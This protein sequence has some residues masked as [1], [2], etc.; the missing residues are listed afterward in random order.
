VTP[1]TAG[2]IGGTGSA[3]SAV[4]TAR[5]VPRRPGPAHRRTRARRGPGRS[6]H[7]LLRATRRPPAG[8]GPSPCRTGC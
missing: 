3:R 1:D 4:G 7:A 6:P 5:R 2:A 8:R